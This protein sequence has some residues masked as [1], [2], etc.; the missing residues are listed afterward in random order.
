MGRALHNPGQD[1]TSE[2]HLIHSGHL[3]NVFYE[4]YKL[5]VASDTLDELAPMRIEPLKS[6]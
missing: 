6:I 1:G 5:Q 4:Y 3:V 2:V